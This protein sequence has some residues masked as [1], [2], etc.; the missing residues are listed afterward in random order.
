MKNA[1][2]RFAEVGGWLLLL[3]AWLCVLQPLATFSLLNDFYK[4][5]L[6]NLVLIDL[7][8]LCLMVTLVIYGIVAGIKLWQMKNGAVKTAKLYFLLSLAY[9]ILV[10]GFYL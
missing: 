1:S 7:V 4:E 6:S 10:I 9:Q 5:G 3:C 8:N 2:N